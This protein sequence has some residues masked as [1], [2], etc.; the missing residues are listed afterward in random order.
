M[1]DP[2]LIR[3][4]PDF[5]RAQVQKL[6]TT[7]PIDA[8]VAA[9]AE[10]R[11]LLSESESLKAERN[12]V[13]KDIG[14]MK[15]AAQREPL[16][17]EMKKVGD[18]IAELDA[19]LREVEARLAAWQLE[20]PNLP[21]DSVPVGP[22]EAHNVIHPV[23]GAM[24]Q[25]DFTPLPHWDLGPALGLMD[26]ERGIKIHGARGYVLKGWG[27]RLERAL[28]N[29]FIDVHTREDGYTEVL[30]PY[31]V[32]EESAFGSAHLPKF[33]DTM[34][35]DAEDNLFL[36]PTAEMPVTNLHRDEILNADELPLKYVAYT[37]CFRR[38]R[39][40][41]GRDTRGL[42][43][44]HQFDKVEMYWFTTPEASYDALTQLV[45]H[46]MKIAELLQ[47]P[48]RLNEMCTGDLGFAATKKF[49]VEM[50]APGSNEWLEVSS[51]SNCEAF[52]ARRANVRFRRK[53]GGPTEFVHTLNGSGLAVGR[54]MI[55][56]LEN[57]QQKDGSVKVPVVLQP[58]MGTDVIK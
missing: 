5:V 33:R 13:S 32:K 29:W 26:F 34:Y 40:A 54:T 31:L 39:A 47:I 9:D 22:D 57:Y 28:I 44:V 10:R 56:V 42:K 53:Q 11:T 2:K 7:A 6:N 58:Y 3:E 21:H 25:F 51:C 24:P 38:E 41:A 1:I 23:I 27:A 18:K 36:V 15:D 37:P 20:V 50:W 8:L 46:A 4:N 49:D 17:A 52:Q 45:G 16:I 14:K 48:Y 55:A 43:R 19:Q 35:Y 12:R 30:P